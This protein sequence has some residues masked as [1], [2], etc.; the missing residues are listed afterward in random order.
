MTWL[1]RTIGVGIA[2]VALYGGFFALWARIDSD[3]ELRG[4]IYFDFFLGGMLALAF[5]LLDIPAPQGASPSWRYKV[6][7]ILW[8][9]VSALLIAWH[10]DQVRIRSSAA[11]EGLRKA[12]SAP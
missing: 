12:G 4:I 10:C 1:L 2:G 6:L 7:M 5:L 11:E 8:G 9:V 3:E